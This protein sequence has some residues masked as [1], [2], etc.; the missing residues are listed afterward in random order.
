[1]FDNRY[2][3]KVH[4]KFLKILLGVNKYTSNIVAHGELG[5]HPLYI[6]I[7]KSYVKYWIKLMHANENGQDLIY[8]AYLYNMKCMKHNETCW[9]TS[10][11]SLLN[12]CGMNEIWVSKNVTMKSSN[13]VLKPMVM[14]LRDKYELNWKLNLYNCKNENTRYIQTNTGNL[15]TYRILKQKFNIEPYLLQISS[16]DERQNCTKLR[17]SNHVLRVETDR[18]RRIIVPFEER[19]CNP[20]TQNNRKI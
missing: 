7:C 17:A 15:S 3:E 14:H 6:D 2:T 5:R 9:M 16:K 19:I 4:L 1:M 20:L 13:V 10:I 18:H 11:R 12:D 8:D